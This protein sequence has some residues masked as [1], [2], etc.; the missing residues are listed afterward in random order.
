MKKRIEGN[1]LCRAFVNEG[2]V[3]KMMIKKSAMVTFS[4]GF[5]ETELSFIKVKKQFFQT[6]GKESHLKLSQQMVGLN[7][8][9]L[10]R[11]RTFLLPIGFLL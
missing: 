3:H 9:C 1:P 2:Y 10:E 11:S 6:W 4:F 5:F 7:C 8:F